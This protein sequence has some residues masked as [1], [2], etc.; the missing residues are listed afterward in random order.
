MWIEDPTVQVTTDRLM[1]YLVS[2]CNEH[3]VLCMHAAGLTAPF[4]INEEIEEEI[5]EKDDSLLPHNWNPWSTPV[6]RQN[7][8][9]L[10]YLAALFLE[11]YGYINIGAFK[12]LTAPLTRAVKSASSDASAASGTTGSARKAGCDKHGV[13]AVLPLKVIICGAGSAGLIAARQLTYFGAQV[14][15]LEARV[16]DEFG[17]KT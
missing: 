15:I 2:Q 8:E 11:R 1:G 14:T 17:E 3:A 7:L 10:A 5:Q 16:S 12:H 13:N 6:S 4:P 9:R